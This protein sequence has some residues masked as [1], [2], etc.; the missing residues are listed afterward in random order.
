MKS[1]KQILQEAAPKSQRTLKDLR[2]D[3]LKPF[4]PEEMQH[5][6]TRMDFHMDRRGLS[7]VQAD[8]QVAIEIHRMRNQNIQ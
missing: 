4:T 3:H 2:L 5:I 6:D 1:F 8:N 7:G